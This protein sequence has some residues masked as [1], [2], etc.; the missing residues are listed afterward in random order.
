[1]D[2]ARLDAVQK[3]YVEEGV[4]P[5]STPLDDLYTNRFVTGR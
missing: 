3:F 4:V 5:K 1:M 2:R